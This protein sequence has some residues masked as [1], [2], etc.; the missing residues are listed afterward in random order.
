MK[1]KLKEKE[2]LEE[3]WI[4]YREVVMGEE[5]WDEIIER[6]QKGINYRKR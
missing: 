4:I 6:V 5:E 1:E 2:E 3:E